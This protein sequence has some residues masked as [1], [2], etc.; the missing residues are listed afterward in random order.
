MATTD[1][2]LTKCATYMA[3]RTFTTT[4][5]PTLAQALSEI[6]TAQGELRA[7]LSL[8]FK[9][10]FITSSS[11]TYTASQATVTLPT[12]VQ[13][14]PLLKVVGEPS[15]STNSAKPLRAKQLDEL[16][17]YPLLGTPVCF[18]VAGTNIMLR[19]I[20]SVAYSLTLWYDAAA[21]DLVSGGAGPS[22][23]VDNFHHLLALGAAVRL[24][25]LLDDD[26]A[27]RLRQRYEKD[28]D[29]LNR[30]YF[31]LVGDQHARLIAPPEGTY[32]P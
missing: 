21:A 29:T 31:E 14:R 8:S 3:M 20:P 2:L 26:K 6:N 15:S 9:R 17:L 32:E 28:L 19:P 23:L 4:T 16:D 25:E 13:N 10:R 24:S 5:N 22:W 30:Y 7:H 11:L 12:A 18:A 27:D 1:E